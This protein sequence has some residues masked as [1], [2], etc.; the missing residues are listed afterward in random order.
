MDACSKP[1]ASLVDE[2]PFD[3]SPAVRQVKLALDTVA[4]Q[5]ECPCLSALLHQLEQCND[6]D[7]HMACSLL[8]PT[9]TT[10]F[11]QLKLV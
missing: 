10:I 1:I 2:R 8:T 3:F 9:Y 7:L 11:V 5:G 4:C 6:C